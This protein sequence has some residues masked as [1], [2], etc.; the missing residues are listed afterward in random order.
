M[1]GVEVTG[2]GVEPPVPPV[3]APPPQLV[4]SPSPAQAVVSSSRCRNLCRPLLRKIHRTMANAVNGKNG[5][6]LG[7]NAA[8][9]GLAEMVSWAVA[10]A[11]PDGVTVAGLNEQV[12]QF[13]RKAQLKFTAELKP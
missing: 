13:G 10:G 7:G 5:R 2:G 9:C 8:D 3:P 12:A 6:E 11:P 4:I 1:N